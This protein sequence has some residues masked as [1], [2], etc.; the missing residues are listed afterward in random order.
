M[1]I[2]RRRA[3]L[4]R[5]LGGRVRQD[6]EALQEPSLASAA[7]ASLSRQCCCSPGFCQNLRAF[8]TASP[9]ASLLSKSDSFTPG[10]RSS[11]LN[12]CTSAD[13]VTSAGGRLAERNRAGA[14]FRNL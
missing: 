12:S 13:L 9:C 10:T 7:L 14:A 3:Q 4:C 6:S 8:L 11:A 1:W 5:E 2:W